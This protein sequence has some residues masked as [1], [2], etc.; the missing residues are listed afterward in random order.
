MVIFYILNSLKLFIKFS[1]NS[2]FQVYFYC[3]NYYIFSMMLYIYN[4]SFNNIGL[5]FNFIF[6]QQIPIYIH[7]IQMKIRYNTIQN[8]I[9]S[10]LYVFYI[11]N[12]NLLRHIKTLICNIFPYNPYQINIEQPFKISMRMSNSIY[13]TAL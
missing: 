9:L 12:R 6:I 4:V 11:L 3:F 1:I 5:D 13:L 7:I 8:F 2:Y 10:L